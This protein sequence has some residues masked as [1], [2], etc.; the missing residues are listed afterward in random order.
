[1]SI[2]KIEFETLIENGTIFYTPMYIDIQ[3]NN[4]A[5]FGNLTFKNT[6]DLS[7]MC[8]Q[9][10][11]HKIYDLNSSHLEEDSFRFK[12]LKGVN[13]NIESLKFN[14]CVFEKEPLIHNN[15]IENISFYDC[16]FN[17]DIY[18]LLKKY[19]DNNLIIAFINCTL[20]RVLI[21]S[22]F[23]TKYK[24]NL[25]RIDEGSI[26]QLQIED[27]NIEN[28]F[29]INKQYNNNKNIV[30]INELVIKN[31]IFKENF[32]LHNCEINKI[33]FEDIDFE[34]HAD[35]YMSK[36]KKGLDLNAI[37]AGKDENPNIYFK[38]IN[39]KGLAIFG[40]CTFQEKIIFEWVTFEGFSHFRRTKF[41][42]GLDLDYTNIEKEMNFFSVK[43]L[44][45]K[46]SKKNTSQETYRIIKHNFEKI[47]NKIEANKYHALELEKK[48]K[49]K[50]TPFFEKIV[51]NI[52]WIT[53]RNGTNW[54]IPL[55]LILT[56]GVL[57]TLGLH[58]SNF[59]SFICDP[60]E[61]I[62]Y[63]AKGFNE[64]FKHVY[65]LTKYKDTWNTF[66]NAIILAVNKFSLGY[67]YYQFLISVRKD[68]RK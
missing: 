8:I 49:N 46:I 30:K 15:A 52:H 24:L 31:S 17:C 61:N 67:L 13:N 68:T 18:N 14:D 66:P 65:I 19:K 56:I 41:C 42:K 6:F 57:T 32:K 7:N 48:R 47:E 29:Y 37:Y 35:F 64:L 54:F 53:S 44:D 9:Y 50:K 36:F 20:S 59:I 63:I 51:L 38:A 11:Q 60:K 34:K 25:F 55:L 22:I 39:F 2:E 43:E 28:K 1:M 21:N 33:Y 4:I 62:E 3:A 23:N 5:W 45:N 16:K 27:V 26:Q 12:Y 58:F 10:N 40:D